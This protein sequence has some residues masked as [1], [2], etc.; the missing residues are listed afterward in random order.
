MQNGESDTIAFA[1]RMLALLDKTSTTS[2]Y[3]YAVILSMMDLVLEKTDEKGLPPESVTTRQLAEKTI[4]L[5][6]PQTNRYLES[7]KILLQNRGGQASILREILTF[8]S[9]KRIGLAA[10]R[11]AARMVD[12]DD[13]ERLLRLVEW[14]LIRY[15]LPL[16]QVIGKQKSEFIYTIGWDKDINQGQVSRYQKGGRS[17]FDNQVRFLP[18]VAKN[19]LHLNALL[20]PLIQREWTRLVA[21]LNDQPES[22]LEDF[23]FSQRRTMVSGLSG[24]LRELQGGYCFYCHG[25][26][27]GRPEV[28]HFIPWS[29]QPNDGLANLV[30]AHKKCN[31]YK[32]AHLAASAHVEQWLRRLD[33]TGQKHD[34]ELVARERRW[35]FGL[36]S[37]LGVARSIYLNLEPE[38]ILW[39]QGEEFEQVEKTTLLRLLGM[40]EGVRVA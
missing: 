32:S 36:D 39:R 14:V 25:E 31:V 3:K 34:L 16:V 30:L 6:W 18:G 8:R 11:H 40:F 21:S 13:Y 37:S 5:Y 9:Q 29:R 28:D 1:E 2:T 17:D 12:P 33:S 7:G 15:P 23:L 4:S 20:R 22:K 10:P 24:P 19:L 35:E 27:K 26:L 38:M